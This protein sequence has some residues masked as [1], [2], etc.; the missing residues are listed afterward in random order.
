MPVILRRRS[1][2][3]FR[4]NTRGA[5]QEELAAPCISMNF[6]KDKGRHDSD[7]QGFYITLTF[8]P[9]YIF[10]KLIGQACF[11]MVFRG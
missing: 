5:D 9:S 10:E 4:R 1:K 7:C 11:I 6:A 2:C 8:W 3:G